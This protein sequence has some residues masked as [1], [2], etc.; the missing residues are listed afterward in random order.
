MTGRLAASQGA[1]LAIDVFHAADPDTASGSLYQANSYDD[2]G[3]R[4]G[5]INRLTP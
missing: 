3:V 4:W 2:A 1:G 5:E